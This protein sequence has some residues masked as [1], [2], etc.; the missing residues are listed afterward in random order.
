MRTERRNNALPEADES[1]NIGTTPIEIRLPDLLTTNHAYVILGGVGCS[2]RPK[3]PYQY[4]VNLELDVLNVGSSDAPLP[5]TVEFAYSEDGGS[6]FTQIHRPGVAELTI[7]ANGSVAM[8]YFWRAPAGE[9]IVRAVVDP[10]DR[11]RESDE[12]NNLSTFPVHL[13]W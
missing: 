6:T 10:D 5:V 7:P 2:L 11:I 12:G 13:P 8:V 3:C 9:F 1:N 4:G